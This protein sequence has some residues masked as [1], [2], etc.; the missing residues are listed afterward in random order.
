V[1]TTVVN[2]LPENRKTPQDDSKTTQNAARRRRPDD[3]YGI[4]TLKMR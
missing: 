4:M 3:K 2:G 1:N